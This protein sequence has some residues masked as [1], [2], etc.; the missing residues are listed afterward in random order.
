MKVDVEDK[1]DHFLLEA[2]LP[3]VSKENVKV[4]I[5]DGVMTISAAVQEEKE[6][7]KKNYVCRERRSGSVSRAFRIDGVQEDGIKAEFKDGVLRLTL[8]KN[9]AP[10]ETVRH[11]EIA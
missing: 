6:E 10:A 5:D 4:S 8:P 1:G 7:T 2:D 9:E 11:I 3:G